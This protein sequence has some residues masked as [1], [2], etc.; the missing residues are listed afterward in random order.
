MTVDEDA[1]LFLDGQWFGGNGTQSPVSV[2]DFLA[3]TIQR[4]NGFGGRLTDFGVDTNIFNR[5]QASGLFDGSINLQA[6][7][8]YMFRFDHSAA[9][10]SLDVEG[11]PDSDTGT[12]TLAPA[13]VPLPAAGWLMLAGLGIFG[14]IRRKRA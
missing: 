10:Q 9:A 12:F 11:V 14:A 8:T 1:T 6:G 3:V 7:L 5:N 2:V 4:D 13:P